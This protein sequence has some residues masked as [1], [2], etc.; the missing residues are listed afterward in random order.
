MPFEELEGFLE[1]GLEGEEEV[2]EEEGR[3]VEEGFLLAMEG[4]SLGAVV[5]DWARALGTSSSSQVLEVGWSG[6]DSHSWVMGL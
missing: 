2:L 3:L 4:L 6:L 5:L 1:E